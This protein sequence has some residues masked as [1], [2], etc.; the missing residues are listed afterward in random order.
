[1]F[2][3]AI[4]RAARAGSLR[5]DRHPTSQS[6]NEMLRSRLDLA[7]FEW[8][9]EVYSHDQTDAVVRISSR[10]PGGHAAASH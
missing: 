6:S 7:D 2:N 8:S 1:M 3:V 10:G 4:C 5:R 9:R